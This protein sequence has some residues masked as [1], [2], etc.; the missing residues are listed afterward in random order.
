MRRVRPVG[1]HR[2]RAPWWAQLV[3]QLARRLAGPAPGPEAM[4]GPE[5]D[6]LEAVMDTLAIRRAVGRDAIASH[7]RRSDAALVMGQP[8]LPDIIGVVGSTMIAWELKADAGRL[9]P[10]QWEWMHMLGGVDA[11]D[12]RTVRPS[13]LD[14]LVDELLRGRLIGRRIGQLRAPRP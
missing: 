8:G 6:L 7:S 10:E 1:A 12:V 2:G 14:E 4:T 5:D 3:A 9:R 11:L 13:D